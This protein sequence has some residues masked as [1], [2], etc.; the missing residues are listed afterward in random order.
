MSNGKWHLHANYGCIC[1]AGYE[2]TEHKEICQVCPRGMYKS[3]PG[4]QPCSLCPLNSI[5]P[6]VGFRICQCLSGYFRIAPN[7]SA[8]HSCLGPPSAPRNLNAIHINGTSVVLSWDK[9]IRSGGFHET[10]YYIQ[11][12]GCQIDTVKYQPGNHVNVTKVTITGLNPQTR[13]QF[14]VYAHNAVSTRTGTMW[15]NVAS[16]MV[17]TGSAPTYLI[18]DIQMNWLNESTVHVKWDVYQVIT[19]LAPTPSPTSSSSSLTTTVMPS[20]NVTSQLVI[21]SD[22]IKI[23]KLSTS[24]SSF[25]F[26]L[27]LFDQSNQNF[28]FGIYLFNNLSYSPKNNND[29]DNHNI[30]DNDTNNVSTSSTTTTT[31]SSRRQQFQYDTTTQPI[32]LTYGTGLIG[33]PDAVHYTSQSEIILYNLYTESGFLIQIRAQIPNAYC[34]YSSPILLLSPRFNIKENSSM[35]KDHNLQPNLIHDIVTDSISNSFNHITSSSSSLSYSIQNR[36]F[37]SSLTDSSL[38][39]YTITNFSNWSSSLLINNYQ[40]NLLSL[41]VTASN[42]SVITIGLFISVALTTMISIILF[43]TLIV[44][45]VYRNKNRRKRIQNK[46]N[47]LF[48]DFNRYILLKLFKSEKSNQKLQTI[49]LIDNTPVNIISSN[50]LKIINQLGENRCG[51]IYLAKLHNCNLLLPSMNTLNHSKLHHFNTINSMKYQYSSIQQNIINEIVS[52]KWNDN[53]VNNNDLNKFNLQ[54]HNDNLLVMNNLNKVSNNQLIINSNLKSDSNYELVVMQYLYHDKLSLRKQLNCKY[55]WNILQSGIQSKMKQSILMMNDKLKEFIQFYSLLNHMNI[56]KFY[57]LSFIEISKSCV[58]YSIITEFCIN[59]SLNTYLKHMLQENQL[60]NSDSNTTNNNIVPFNLHAVIKMLL[61]ILSGLEYL[62]THSFI[63]ENFTSSSVLLDINF[64]CKLKIQLPSTLSLNRKYS[65]VNKKK[66]NEGFFQPLLLN[67]EFTND[68]PNLIRFKE[69][70]RLE[71]HEL[72]HPLIMNHSDSIQRSF[73]C[74]HDSN[75]YDIYQ[76]IIENTLSLIENTNTSY[77]KYVD[78]EVN[79]IHHASD[80]MLQSTVMETNCHLSNIYSFSQLIIELII[81]H[82]L[83]DN[84]CKFLEMFRVYG[85]NHDIEC[86]HSHL[87]CYQNTFPLD[88]NYMSTLNLNSPTTNEITNS[89]EAYS[90]LSSFVHNYHHQHHQQQQDLLTRNDGNLMINSST[91]FETTDK[92]HTLSHLNQLTT[93][94]HNRMIKND[95]NVSTIQRIEHSNTLLKEI[96]CYQLLYQLTIQPIHSKELYFSNI[97]QLIR[98]MIPQSKLDELLIACRHS[99]LSMRPSFTEIRGQLQYVIETITMSTDIC[100]LNKSTVNKYSI[101]NTLVDLNENKDVPNTNQSDDLN[102]MQTML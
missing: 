2:M 44:L 59:G 80:T 97:C 68:I 17:T 27:C 3:S 78:N 37:T 18:T 93:P 36:K 11:C 56:V 69:Q 72:K 50:Q 28:P 24:L 66:V 5:A 45:C 9:P 43:I 12:Q 94:L 55:H 19:H 100:T 95:I 20:I 102:L 62:S 101:H 13:Y 81:A 86:Q 21:D 23:D 75:I 48:P 4:L 71:E 15:T 54:L 99:F 42:S 77:Y 41:P 38:E 79:N 16:V 1:D 57:G 51:P 14:D 61:Q 52:N 53:P 96:D 88:K 29:I 82:L 63:V 47:Q 40:T 65:N 90:Q 76:I 26:Q 64:N 31:N 6:R 25:K 74:I 46:I 84:K 89:F 49:N 83:L 98:M 30:S 58:T 87:H 33:H 67:N 70:E 35:Y 32:D 7:V 60:V 85:Q 39:N 73:N 10:L 92:Y 22:M 34:P 8:E 91:L